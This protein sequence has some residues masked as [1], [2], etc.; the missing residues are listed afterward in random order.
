MAPRKNTVALEV[1]LEEIKKSLNF[2]SDELSKVAKQQMLLDLMGEI[3]QL[4]TIIK[5]KDNKISDLERRIEDLE[6]NTRMEDVIINGLDTTHR[7]YA[8]TTNGKSK[9]GEDAPIEELQT[10]E[11]QVIKF[12]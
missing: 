2:M 8:S 9:D 5:E 12:I 4:R 6:Q 3:K 11:R 10:L 1:E 7:S